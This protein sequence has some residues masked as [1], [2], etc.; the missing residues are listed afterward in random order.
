MWAL[1]IIKVTFLELETISNFAL[2]QN[3]NRSDGNIWS[4]IDEL[5]ANKHKHDT[6]NENYILL[7][8][9]TLFFL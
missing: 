4:T 8:L 5:N 9:I 3:P 1:G 7:F 2:W 6:E